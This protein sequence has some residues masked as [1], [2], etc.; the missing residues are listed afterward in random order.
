MNAK[1]ITLS[2]IIVKN[3][4]K[5]RRLMGLA[6]WSSA[7]GAGSI[8]GRGTNIPHATRCSQKKKKD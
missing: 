7:G 6:W 4:D 2:H 8:P 5:E 1:Q 3:K